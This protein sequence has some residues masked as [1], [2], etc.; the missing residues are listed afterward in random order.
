MKDAIVF[1]SKNGVDILPPT[2]IVPQC[3]S[4]NEDDPPS[5]K[6]SKEKSSNRDDIIESIETIK[7]EQI[8]NELANFSSR[9]IEESTPAD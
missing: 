3:D 5:S 7:E 8:C 9:I 2:E 1:P 6:D 4:I